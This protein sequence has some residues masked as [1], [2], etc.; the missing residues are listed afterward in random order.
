MKM[1]LDVLLIVLK[2]LGYLGIFLWLWLGMLGIPVPNEAIVTTIGYLSTTNMLQGNKVFLVGYLGIVASL[3]TSYLL[4]RV[5][6]KTL[7]NHLSKKK[8]TKTSLRKALHLIKK[9]H[10][11]SL[12]VS[13][14]IPGVRIFVPFLYGMMRLSYLRF[15]LLS[16]STAFIW[17]SL[18]FLL[19]MVTG[20][21]EDQAIYVTIVIVFSVSIG[22]IVINALKK[23]KKRV[24]ESLHS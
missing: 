12:I 13:Y 18:F 17:F 7:V 6:G 21:N 15:A 1:E 24:E 19:G 20:T 11:Y 23:K 2:E 8:G 4:G 3:S 5:F 14:F 16:Y 9:Y 10:V 22:S